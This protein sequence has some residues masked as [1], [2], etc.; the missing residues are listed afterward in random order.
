[1][2]WQPAFLNPRP[3]KLSFI[4]L[5]SRVWDKYIIGNIGSCPLCMEDSWDSPTLLRGIMDIIG[6]IWEGIKISWTIIPKLT[7]GITCFLTGWSL[8]QWTRNGSRECCSNGKI[9]TGIIA[10]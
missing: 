8:N 5:S 2:M 10:T 4:Q 1:M 6:I 3:L 9:I 7:D